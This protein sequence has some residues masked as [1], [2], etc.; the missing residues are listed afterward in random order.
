MCFVFP[1]CEST[2][3]VIYRIYSLFFEA[4]LSKDQDMGPF[5]AGVLFTEK[6]SLLP[7][8][9]YLAAVALNALLWQPC[10]Y[11][12]TLPEYPVDSRVCPPNHDTDLWIPENQDSSGEPLDHEHHDPMEKVSF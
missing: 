2:V 11:Q 9:P 8:V 6:T 7:A 10:L 12:L 1:S 4:I 3:L 5:L